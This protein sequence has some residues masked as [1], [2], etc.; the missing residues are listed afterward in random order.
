MLGELIGGLLFELLLYPVLK[1]FDILVVGAKRATR[2]L[3]PA[4]ESDNDETGEKRR[5]GSRSGTHRG[6]TDRHREK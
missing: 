3:R 6:T 1:L 5:F 2:R 4:S